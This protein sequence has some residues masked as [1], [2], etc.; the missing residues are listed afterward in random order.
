MA[1]PASLTFTMAFAAGGGLGYNFNFLLKDPTFTIP[2]SSPIVIPIVTIA[3]G[4]YPLSFTDPGTGI[5]VKAGPSLA[6]S[7]YGSIKATGSLSIVSSLATSV[8]LTMSAVRFLD[9]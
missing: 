6:V 2:S 8:Q 1:T 9:F 7:L 4:S 5:T 3:A